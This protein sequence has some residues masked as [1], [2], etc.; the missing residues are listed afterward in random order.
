MLEDKNQV[1]AEEM[2]KKRRE[3]NI[4]IHGISEMSTDGD[5]TFA[6]NLFKALHAVPTPVLQIERIGQK[7]EST[8]EP[9]KRPIK[10]TFKSEEDKNGVLDNLRYLKG[11]MEYKGINITP[12]YTFKERQLIKDFSI[13]ASKKNIEEEKNGSSYVWRVRGTPKNGMFLK[14]LNAR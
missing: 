9:G 7:S 4:I 13:E 10:I 3:R 8:Q 5:K 11:K 14:R 12:D 1:L 6:R 2:D